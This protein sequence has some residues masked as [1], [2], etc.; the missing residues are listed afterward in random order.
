MASVFHFFVRDVDLVGDTKCS[1]GK[2]LIS[3]APNLFSICTAGVHV[4]QVYKTSTDRTR[5]RM[6]LIFEQS[7]MFL[8]FQIGCTH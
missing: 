8:S 5:N 4:S 2:H 6:S 1:F 3:A 7:Y